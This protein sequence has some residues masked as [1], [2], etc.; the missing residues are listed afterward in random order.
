MNKMKYAQFL[1]YALIFFTTTP[2]LLLLA[3]IKWE[4]FGTDWNVFYISSAVIISRITGL[5]GVVLFFW[6][7]LLANRF[8][9]GRF[10]SDTIWLNSIHKKL[11]IYGTLFVFIHPLLQLYLLGEG[12][13]YL[14]RPDFAT[15]YQTYLSFGRIAYIF[16]TVIWISS[17]V[18]RTKLSYRVWVYIHALAYPLI[19]FAIM[20]SKDIGSTLNVYP[21]LGSA[22]IFL[23]WLFVAIAIHRW[24]YTWSGLGK[25]SYIVS[26]IKKYPGD[27]SVFTLTPRGK[28]IKPELGQYC[29]ISRI[30]FGEE[31]PFSVMDYDEKSGEVTFGIKSLGAFTKKIQQTK[32]GDVWFLDGPY[33]VFT[34][35]GHNARSKVFIAGGIGITPFCG[36]ISKYDSPDTYLLYANRS[37]REA[38]WRDQLKEKLGNRYVDVISDEEILDDTQTENGL[39]T[40]EIIQRRIP[41]DVLLNSPIFFCGNL[42][43]Y[44]VTKK[45]LIEL[46]VAEEN[47]FY[48]E[49]SL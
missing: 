36:V 22:W 17:A 23:L 41:K 14:F 39:L 38:V 33:G 30:R 16:F 6:Q 4:F 31:H 19:F 8:L 15:Q 40:K 27:V 11:G 37:Q 1:V 46:G 5:V 32:E 26:S 20:H 43:F 28:K 44:K 25:R 3:D 48:E 9:I 47:I 12:V 13:L 10:L 24:V 29:Y 35:E 7:L 34:K 21:V 49:F 45:M 42:G 2:F 18:L